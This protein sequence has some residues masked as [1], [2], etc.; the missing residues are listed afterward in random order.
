MYGSARAGRVDSSHKC[1]SAGHVVPMLK[2]RRR[3]RTAKAVMVSPLAFMRH[4]VALIRPCA[5]LPLGRA[6]DARAS[7][8]YTA[9]NSG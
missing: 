9:T 8:S 7:D 1:A 5:G 2:S 6:M 4:Q 3:N